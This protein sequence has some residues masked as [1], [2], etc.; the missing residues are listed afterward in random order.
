[1]AISAEEGKKIA[2]N[3]EDVDVFRELMMKYGIFGLD[4]ARKILNEKIKGKLSNT[5]IEMREE[6]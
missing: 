2:T 3:K 4:E 5:V 6:E 1:M